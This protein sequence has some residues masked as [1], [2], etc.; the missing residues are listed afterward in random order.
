MGSLFGKRIR[1]GVSGSIAA[2]K[3]ILLLRQLVQAG[4]D[5]RVILTAAASDFV[6]PLVLETLCG[7]PVVNSLVHGS[8]WANHVML[9]RDADLMIIAP[10]SANTIAKMAGG[11]CDNALLAVFLSAT[12]PVWLAP[13]MDEDMW[14]HQAT[15]HNL[16]VLKMRGVSI[17]PV[18]TGHLASGL[19]GAGRMAE[20]EQIVALVQDFFGRIGIL[21]G[22][23]VLVTAGPTYEPFDPVRFVGNYSSGKMG[24]AIAE[25]FMQMGARVH[26]VLGPSSASVPA[27]IEV[28]RVQS[29]QQMFEACQHLWPACNIAVMAAAVADYRPKI[30]QANKIKKADSE[31]LVVE[32][33]RTPDILKH[34][35]SVKHDS[36]LLVGF[37]LETQDEE[38]NAI[39]KLRAKNADMIVLNSLRDAG[40]G[41]GGDTNKITIFE[42]N[43]EVH[44][45]ELQSKQQAARSLVE[46]ISK[47]LHE[48]PQ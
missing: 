9:G 43:G 48:S 6:S 36:Q 3:A 44:R 25:N 42:K 5:V 24:I 28:S 13:A 4:A 22:K 27:G 46:L 35:G 11:L 34:C 29:A 18:G 15:Q 38:N 1:I 47:R 30:V 17:L 39:S 8:A 45:Y 21:S 7:K 32:L 10:A 2:Y 33:E 41:F 14:V 19:T 20:P 37:A 12:C 26:L 23:T 16:D 40:A 31:G